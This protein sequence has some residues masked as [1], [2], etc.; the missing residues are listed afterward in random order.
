MLFIE[1]LN[2]IDMF[3]RRV[4]M[5]NSEASS[6]S[7]EIEPVPQSLTHSRSLL[8]K[9]ESEFFYESKLSSQSIYITKEFWVVSY[10]ALPIG[11]PLGH[12]V[13]IIEGTH[14]EDT[15]TE[16]SSTVPY[17]F[18]ASLVVNPHNESEIKLQ[19]SFNHPYEGLYQECQSSKSI[20][21]W[22]LCKP[23]ALNL[24]NIIT[25]ESEKTIDYWYA[26][27]ESKLY[28]VKAHNCKTWAI[29]ILKE[30]GIEIKGTKVD[31]KK[32]EPRCAICNRGVVHYYDSQ[33]NRKGLHEY[34]EVFY[35]KGGDKQYDHVSLLAAKFVDGQW[36]K[37]YMSYYPT[38]SNGCV[39]PVKGKL[40][41][42]NCDLRHLINSKSCLLTNLDVGA[43]YNAIEKLEARIE[44][45]DS[46][47]WFHI[48]ACCS[49]PLDEASIARAYIRQCSGLVADLLEVGGIE[50]VLPD[51]NSGFSLLSILLSPSF[52]F[53]YIAAPALFY[54]AEDY[55][56]PLFVICLLAAGLPLH[57]IAI[58]RHSSVSIKKTTYCLTV[59]VFSAAIFG[60]SYLCGEI[61]SQLGWA[62]DDELEDGGISARIVVH[63]KFLSFSLLIGYIGAFVCN[64]L[65][66]GIILFTGKGQYY[67]LYTPHQVF[68]LA[69]KC[70]ESQAL[71]KRTYFNVQATK[72]SANFLLVLGGVVGE[73]IQK[74][75]VNDDKSGV[76]GLYVGLTA[77]FLLYASL[78]VSQRLRNPIFY[79]FFKIYQ[80]A[81]WMGIISHRF[82]NCLYNLICRSSRCEMPDEGGVKFGS[83]R[84]DTQVSSPDWKAES[85]KEKAALRE[86]YMFHPVYM[87]FLHFTLTS[88]LVFALPEVIDED[89]YNHDWE[90]FGVLL[91]F[92]YL[93]QLPFVMLYFCEQYRHHERDDADQNG[94][95]RSPLLKG[96]ENRSSNGTFFQPSSNTSPNLVG[97]TQ[98]SVEST[99]ASV[100]SNQNSV[101]SRF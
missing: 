71:E 78:F 30:A 92:A 57:M 42:F 77:G 67:R 81:H 17:I 53:I 33:R 36:D 89:V 12:S 31:Y 3:L 6:D 21:S 76:T 41:E 66:W 20:E 70:S 55:N 83:Q 94:S 56:L 93:V 47:M 1:S 2:R 63:L 87:F 58:F 43:V 18:N 8:P 37:K 10:V 97:S 27:A 79:L 14:T 65:I 28:K 46:N 99:Q 72:F 44:Q 26:G 90:Y 45:S 61:L 82:T 64:L 13:I 59:G 11:S 9:Q 60:A 48:M 91:G 34:I 32:A 24:F 39:T 80:L 75:G 85:I 16:G 68:Q 84:S 19:W 95:D 25:R 15:D 51:F 69:K 96:N 4:D 35:K 88:T 29:D 5:P 100:D 98:A 101:E 49:G 7:S 54:Q 74:H 73:A 22:Y 23:E 38:K 52:S 62:S 50:F 40:R 86:D